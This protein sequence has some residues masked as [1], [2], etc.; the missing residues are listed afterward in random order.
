MNEVLKAGEVVIE[1]FTQTVF[2]RSKALTVATAA[3]VLEGEKGRTHASRARG[4]DSIAHIQDPAYALIATLGVEVV[5][6]AGG[7]EAIRGLIDRVE[8]TERLQVLSV[9]E[10]LLAR[11]D[12]VW[13]WDTIVQGVGESTV[14][15]H[16]SL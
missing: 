10:P 2:D 1:A 8:Q 5:A 16:G 15:S 13:A 4:F 7:R 9:A 3:A 6:P 12:P 11:V 14:L